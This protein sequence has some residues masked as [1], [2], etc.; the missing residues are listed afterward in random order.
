MR[1]R[2][3][4][5]FIRNLEDEIYLESFLVAAIV[6]MLLVR[7]YLYLAGFP[8]VGGKGLHVAHL[9]WGGLLMVAG[10]ALF[11]NYLDRTAH[12]IAVVVAGAGF[13]LF[14]DEIGK[15]IS[16]DNNYFFRP[17]ASLIYVVFV[18]L[19]LLFHLLQRER[20]VTQRE[21]LLNALEAYREAVVR[22]Y[23][24]ASIERARS[25]L[26][27]AGDD[28]ALAEPIRALVDA[29]PPETPRR[30]SAWQ[31]WSEKA[32]RGYARTAHEWWFPHTVNAFFALEAIVTLGI[33]VVSAA[34][35]TG[36]TIPSEL[37]SAHAHRSLVREADL[38]FATLAS[39]VVLVA[40]V[41]M[42]TSRLRAYRLFKLAMLIS[43]FLTQIFE[44][45]DIQF[46]ALVGL[47]FNLIGLG[48][49]DTMINEERA[50]VSRNLTA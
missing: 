25:Y 31:R 26:K 49:A 8:Q 50:A 19:Y 29:C 2:G 36:F 21:Y 6:T 37:G 18:S 12:H 30:P 24:R 32:I 44:F 10:I 45:Y 13:G 33:A 28:D 17:A 47:A 3:N 7:F 22:G 9:L 35:V 23:N 16:S 39:L 41:V 34:V 38:F 46:A 5:L 14:I 1:R 27:R 48:L 40:S 20:N 43:V 11:V 42:F 4:T 15:F